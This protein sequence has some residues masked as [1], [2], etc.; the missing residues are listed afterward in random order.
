MSEIWKTIKEYPSYQVSNFGNIRSIN[1]KLTGKTQELKQKTDKDGYKSV[2]IFNNGKGGHLRTHRLVACTFLNEDIKTKLCVCHKNDIRDDNRLDNLFFGTNAEN[3]KDMKD[4]KRH[5]HGM[6][7]GRAKLNNK[8]VR[9]IRH[10]YA[11]GNTTHKRIAELFNVSKAVI[12]RVV[13][14]KSWTHL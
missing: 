13:N 11:I 3:I 7:Q 14:K 4:K 9:V 1:Y 8:Q 2:H 10:L 5:P 6:K 12:G